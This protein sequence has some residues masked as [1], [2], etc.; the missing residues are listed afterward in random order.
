MLPVH[1]DIILKFN[2]LVD[3]VVFVAQYGPELECLAHA[4]LL[5]GNQEKGAPAG[6]SFFLLTG[7]NLNEMSE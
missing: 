1:R 7:M 4:S 2:G 5:K 6:D 3:G